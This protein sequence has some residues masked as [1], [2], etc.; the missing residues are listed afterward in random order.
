MSVSPRSSAVAQ[1]QKAPGALASSV[2]SAVSS[3]A[4]SVTAV[5]AIRRSNG[6][7]SAA[8]G[9]PYT[10]D[11]IDSAVVDI[12]GVPVRVATVRVLYEMKRDT[13]RPQDQA[14]AEA[15]R[16]RFDVEE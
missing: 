15:L 16:S 1:S 4:P 13:V 11:E 3:S 7:S 8:S 10:F 5:T 2:W 9:M 6:T 14:D 12:D